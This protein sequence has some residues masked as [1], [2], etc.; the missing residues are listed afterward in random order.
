MTASKKQREAG[1]EDSDR[2]VSDEA[3][4]KVAKEI[5]VKF[6]EIGRLSPANFPETFESVYR[7][8]KDTVR[9]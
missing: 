6:I 1:L 2:P 3:V 9:S 8:V 5:V 4:L 7:A